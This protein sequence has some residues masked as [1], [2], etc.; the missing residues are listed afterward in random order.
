[1]KTSASSII[2]QEAIRLAKS[3]RSYNSLNPEEKRTLLGSICILR[4]S[5]LYTKY[6]VLSLGLNSIVDLSNNSDKKPSQKSLFND[7]AWQEL[8]N[9]SYVKKHIQDLPAT[10]TKELK[11][12]KKVTTL[13]IHC[14]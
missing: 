8:K 11:D 7:A 12:I 5:Q 10:I 14:D 1:M 3:G 6:L 4:Y 9:R 13:F 2:K